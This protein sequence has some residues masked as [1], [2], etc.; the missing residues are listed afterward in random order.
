MFTNQLL[1]DSELVLYSPKVERFAT[2]LEIVEHRDM[3]QQQVEQE[4]LEK[5]QSQEAL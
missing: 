2:Y 4:R 1:V 3:A 5:E